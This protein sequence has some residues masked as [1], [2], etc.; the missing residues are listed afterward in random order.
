MQKKKVHKHAYDIFEMCYKL[1]RHVK[2]C[3][4]MLR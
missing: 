2:I 3:Y 1:E 4:D